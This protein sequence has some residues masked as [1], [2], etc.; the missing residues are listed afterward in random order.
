[1]L[2]NSLNL[3][4]SLPILY[5]SWNIDVLENSNDFN[6]DLSP[7]SEI[8]VESNL[9][10]EVLLIL[11]GLSILFLILLYA[12]YLILQ[13]NQEE[14]YSISHANS[15]G[16]A[17]APRPVWATREQQPRRDIVLEKVRQMNLPCYNTISIF[18]NKDKPPHVAFTPDEAL[19]AE[20]RLELVGYKNRYIVIIGVTNGQVENTLIK[21]KKWPNVKDGDTVNAEV[22]IRP[23]TETIRDLERTSPARI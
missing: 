22:I 10:L 1:M 23:L 9:K 8:I 2:D 5:N 15:L 16:P 13:M 4:L 11:L 18:N 3:H 19:E 14:T 12:V 21:V 7:L 6:L 20:Q 17:L